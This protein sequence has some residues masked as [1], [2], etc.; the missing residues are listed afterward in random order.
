[1]VFEAPMKILIT[2]F[3]TYITCNTR[4]VCWNLKYFTLKRRS[5]LPNHA[6]PLSKAVL[7]KGILPTCKQG[8]IGS[9][10]GN[11][12]GS[13]HSRGPYEHF[14]TNEKAK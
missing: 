10:S 3:L 8:S 7:S 1:M 6:G 13:G 14:T 12:S 9:G 2:K 4:C 5:S 11:A